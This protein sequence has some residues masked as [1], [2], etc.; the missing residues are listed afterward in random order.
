MS[1]GSGA[2]VRPD[3]SKGGRMPVRA[4]PPDSAFT[5]PL[6]ESGR[7][8][9]AGDW[10]RI[11]VNSDVMEDEPDLAIG[12]D[13][14]LEINGKESRWQIVGVVPTLA[15]GPEAY[16]PYESYAQVTGTPGS[17][18]HVRV[19]TTE[20]DA[21]AQRRM[22]ARL[23]EAFELAGMTV[24]ST[25]TSE[26][27]RSQYELMFNVVVI[28][29][30]IMAL[31]LAAVGGLGLTTTMSINVLERIRE[32]GVLRAI[33]ASNMAVRRI[34]LTEGVVI[35]L[36]SWGAGILLSL[37]VGAVMSEQVGMALLGIPL[38]YRYSLPAAVMW[39]FALL[40]IAIVASLGPARNAVRL[41]VREVL[42]YE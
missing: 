21:Q 38:N 39:F 6:L 25:N 37:P 26:H 29:L 18:T 41:T 14:V 23:A 17:A 30:I 20:H 28:F 11:V 10:N 27:I 3:D 13:I 24:A 2:R 31:L 22:E 7:W 5:S 8:L 32:I 16:V 42:A 35:G 12:D 36:L 33:G 4:V 9:E 15:R 40:M 1:Q 34:V 19:S